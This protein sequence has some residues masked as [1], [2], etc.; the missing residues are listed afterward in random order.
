[1]IICLGLTII[2]LFLFDL[3]L[4]YGRVVV[5]DVSC[6]YYFI[7]YKVSSL[8]GKIRVVHCQLKYII[9]FRRQMGICLSRLAI[10]DAFF[11]LSLHPSSS[12]MPL[13]PYSFSSRGR[14]VHLFWEFITADTTLVISELTPAYLFLFS[15]RLSWASSGTLPW[16]MTGKKW[17]LLFCR[18]KEKKAS[19]S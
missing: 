4:L 7:L 2:L 16:K 10:Y 3:C 18:W 5:G 1:M 11:V 8:W 14:K 12:N 15:S 6:Y 19:L 13:Y 9:R 17:S